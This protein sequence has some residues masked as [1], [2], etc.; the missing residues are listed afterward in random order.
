MFDGFRERWRGPGGYQ[1]LLRVAVPMVL[2]MASTT[3]M[4]F[5]DRIFLANYSLDAIAASVPAGTVQLLLTSF[6]FGMVEY[7]SV[8][9]AQYTGAGRPERVGAALWQ[10][11][12]FCVPASLLLWLGGAYG[13]SLF[14]FSGHPP[15]VVALER[16]YFDICTRFSGLSLLG[17]ALSCFFSGRGLTRPV[18]AANMLGALVNIPLDYLLINGL[19]GLPELG[20]RGAA[21]ATVIGWAVVA[22]ILAGLVFRPAHELRFRVW[23]ARRPDPDLLRR[24]WRYGAPGGGQVFVDLFAICFF[25]VMLGRLGTVELAASN[26]ALSVNLLAFLPLIGMCIAVSVLAGQAMG[27]GAPD[28]A[29]RT[30]GSALRLGLTA[31]GLAGLVLI[32]APEWILSWFR[33]RDMADADFAAIVAVGA[34]ILRFVAFYSLGD[35]VIQVYF[36]ALKGAGDTGFVLRSLALCNVLLIVVPVAFFPWLGLGI[37]AYWWAISA[38]VFVLAWVAWRRFRAGRWRT[39]SVIER[40]GSE[41][42]G[43]DGPAA[44]A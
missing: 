4:Q 27:A 11:I 23:S 34:P 44:R 35:T 18:M 2:S 33:T 25:V 10:G 17:A 30:V 38:N 43:P 31:M 12:W 40:A 26:M 41:A 21:W 3:L 6:F 9:V 29:V 37:W 5:T 32:L 8:F 19:W 20:I 14:E 24:L 15:A 36:S 22:A 13:A 28:R 7:V 16:Q 1:E 42:P 39:L